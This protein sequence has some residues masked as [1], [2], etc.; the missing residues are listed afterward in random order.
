MTGPLIPAGGSRPSQFSIT[1]G[2]DLLED[3][4]AEAT[5]PEKNTVYPVLYAVADK[6]VDTEYTVVDDPASP[7][8][9]FVLAKNDLVVKIRIE[10]VGSF[11]I[12]YIG[13]SDG[14]PGFDDLPEGTPQSP[15]D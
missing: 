11:A 4:A 3:W 9:F 10:A 5:Q 2:L 12:L 7:L 15:P 13:P 14:A 8:D 1:S 6:T